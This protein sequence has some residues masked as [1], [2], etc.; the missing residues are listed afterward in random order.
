[1]GVIGITRP[2]IGQKWSSVGK[3]LQLDPNSVESLRSMRRGKEDRVLWAPIRQHEPHY[4]IEFWYGNWKNESS[5]CINPERV[6]VKM[7]VSDIS[8]WENPPFPES[9][10]MLNLLCNSGLEVNDVW[11]SCSNYFF[12]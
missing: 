10:S 3:G 12:T 7:V 6:L 8:C 5:V 11:F 9:G 1:M 4:F 2:R